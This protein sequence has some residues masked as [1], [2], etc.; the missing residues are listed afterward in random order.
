MRLENI[1]MFRCSSCNQP[2]LFLNKDKA[3]IVDGYVENGELVCKNCDQRFPIIDGVPNLLPNEIQKYLEHLKKDKPPPRLPKQYENLVTQILAMDRMSKA[4]RQMVVDPHT[5]VEAAVHYEKYEDLFLR[6][7]MREF[8]ERSDGN[9][10]GVVFIEVG[11]GPGRYLVQFGGKI[12]SNDNACEQF[13]K[14]SASSDLYSYDPLYEKN[15][16]LIVGI[17]FS[18]RMIRSALEWL[19]QNKLCDL[20]LNDRIVMIQ[21]ASQFLN[22]SFQDTPYKD[23]HKIVTCVFQTLGNQMERSL[24]IDLLKKMYKWAQPHGII[25]VSVF[26]R[27]VFHHYFE[28]YYLG[29]EETIGP[30]HRDEESLEKA[31]LKT[32]WG[33]YS[34]WFDRKALRDLFRDAGIRNVDIRSGSGLR[35]GLPLFRKKK[36]TDYLNTNDQKL[37]RERAIFATVKI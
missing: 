7:R 12:E 6:T 17:D 28:P 33:V 5:G 19:K 25:F 14:N 37:V 18:E 1:S 2:T 23:S 22:L 3:K 24:Q 10:K 11:S 30:I 32:K 9:H 8:I 35:S 13:R 29:I 34:R 15:L 26:N 16:K 31:I 36:E 20:F 27:G 21:A 4:Y